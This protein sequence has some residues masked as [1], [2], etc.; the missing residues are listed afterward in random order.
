[1]KHRKPKKWK[2][3]SKIEIE[4][5]KRTNSRIKILGQALV[6]SKLDWYS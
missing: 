5:R 1:M 3:R 2:R 4:S 6:S